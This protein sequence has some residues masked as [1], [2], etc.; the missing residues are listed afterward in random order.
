MGLAIA[1]LFLLPVLVKP[2]VQS[3]VFKPM[4]SVVYFLFIADVILLGWL[5]AQVV[6]M[7]YIG[8]G[9]FATLFYFSIILI[10]IPL[11]TKLENS[12]FTLNGYFNKRCF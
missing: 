3:P 7:P 4:F 12:M 5:G 11:I 10:I 8:L 6:E 9:Q 1:I 2:L